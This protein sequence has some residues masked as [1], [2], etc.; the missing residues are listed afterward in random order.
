MIHVMTHNA[1]LQDD[2]SKTPVAADDDVGAA[3]DTPQVQTR[4][5]QESCNILTKHVHNCTNHVQGICTT[6][7]QHLHIICTTFM[8]G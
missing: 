2:D 7:E 8:R 5:T 3:V 6:L 1:M 4:D